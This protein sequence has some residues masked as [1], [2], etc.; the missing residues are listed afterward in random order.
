[1]ACNGCG[2][3]ELFDDPCSGDTVC[4]TC[5]L[6]AGRETSLRV[7]YDYSGG[8][9]STASSTI[10]NVIRALELEPASDWIDFV[11]EKAIAVKRITRRRVCDIL[12]QEDGGMYDRIRT[13]LVGARLRCPPPTRS[14][15]Q[16]TA[17]FD[18]YVHWIRSS[19]L[20]ET[21]DQTRALNGVCRETVDRLPGLRFVLPPLFVVAVYAYMVRAD[22]KTLACIASDTHTNLRSVTRILKKIKT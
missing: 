19:G 15:A 14:E 20:C 7:S 22:Q 18:D 11:Q 13:L 10:V 8:R 3:P 4:T 1:M 5:G 21:R 16:P 12:L 17:R 2:G 9:L 6:V